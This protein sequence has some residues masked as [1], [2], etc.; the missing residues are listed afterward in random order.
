MEASSSG[1]DAGTR[2]TR[3]GAEAQAPPGRRLP[4]FDANLAAGRCLQ[5]SGFLVCT[6][7][8]RK[9]ASSR[10]HGSV[11]GVGSIALAPALGVGPGAPSCPKS[12]HRLMHTRLAF[13]SFGIA[14]ARDLA[15]GWRR[16]TTERPTKLASRPNWVWS[17]SVVWLHGYSAWSRKWKPC[18]VRAPRGR[19]GGGPRRVLSCS[20]RSELRA[21]TRSVTGLLFSGSLVPNRTGFRMCPSSSRGR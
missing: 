21:S 8:A 1:R 15:V 13:S 2:S 17:R 10:N 12:S 4:W 18:T 3:R 11:R 7:R 5:V 9:C 14:A 6:H 16:P 20:T 19:R